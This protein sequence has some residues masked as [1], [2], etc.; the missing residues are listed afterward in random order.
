VYVVHPVHMSGSLNSSIPKQEKVALLCAAPK[1]VEF[2]ACR[3]TEILTCSANTVI[4]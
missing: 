1:S 4:S 2:P 3:D